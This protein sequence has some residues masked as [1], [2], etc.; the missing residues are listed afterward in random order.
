MC[1]LYNVLFQ[2]SSPFGSRESLSSVTT[3]TAS[4]QD[5]ENMVASLGKACHSCFHFL[6]RWMSVLY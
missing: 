3:D 6:N 5:N 1:I 2:T 4:K